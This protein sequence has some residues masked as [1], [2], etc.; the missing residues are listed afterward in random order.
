MLKLFLCIFTPVFIAILLNLYIY[1]IGWNNNSNTKPTGLPPSY[2]IAIV[3]TIILGLLGYTFY[4]VYPSQSAWI[5]VMATIYCLAYP[6][7][8]SGLQQEFTYYNMLSLVIAIITAI[9]VFIENKIAT[10]YIVPFVLWT[11]YVNI[12]TIIAKK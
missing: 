11:A 6:F 3:W 12:I 7:L 2:V 1:L 9:S 4:I 5:I 10:L 8:T